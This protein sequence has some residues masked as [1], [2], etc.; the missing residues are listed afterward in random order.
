M[1]IMRTK[2][3]VLTFL[4]LSIINLCIY[5]GTVAY[6]WG[7]MQSA[8]DNHVAVFSAPAY[9]VIFSGIPFIIATVIFLLIAVVISKRK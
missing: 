2:K 5:I 7:Y 9:V 6:N 8:I 4:S 1:Y 3:S